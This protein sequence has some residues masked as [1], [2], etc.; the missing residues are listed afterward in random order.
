MRPTFDG[1][2]RYR[3]RPLPFITVD[4][5]TTISF[6]ENG[7]TAQLRRGKLRFGAGLTFDAG[8]EDS[9]TGGAFAGGDDRL[10]VLGMVS[11]T[12]TS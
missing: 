7:L 2:D 5:R 12:P 9:C 3:A 6:G 4:W 10:A 11:Q 1:S 8:R